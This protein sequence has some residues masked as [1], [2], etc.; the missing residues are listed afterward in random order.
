MFPTTLAATRPYTETLY[1]GATHSTKVVRQDSSTTDYVFSG[2]T[3][4]QAY[5]LSKAFDWQP[6]GRTKRL[7]RSF[8]VALKSAAY[9]IQQSIISDWG[10]ETRSSTVALTGSASQTRVRPQVNT[11]AASLI[12]TQ[13]QLGD[14]SAVASYWELDRWEAEIEIDKDAVT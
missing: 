4:F 7:M 2:A 13:V 14:A 6:I 12:T 5:V 3:A 9:T 11:D 10:K 1:V 8:I